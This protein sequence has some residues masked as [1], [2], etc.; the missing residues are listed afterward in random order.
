MKSRR[1][2]EKRAMVQRFADRMLPLVASGTLRAVV[3]Q[4]FPLA[5]VVQ[6]HEAMERG[7]GFGKIVL[8]V[9]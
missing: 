9:P 7:G 4:V 8:T 5:H 2:D 3:S 1:P 6:A